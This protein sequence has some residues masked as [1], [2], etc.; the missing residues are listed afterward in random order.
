MKLFDENMMQ[1]VENPK[2]WKEVVHQAVQLLVENNKATWELEQKIYE[3]TE[4]FGAYYVLE[5]GIALVHGPAG[6]HC[7]QAATSTLILN[8]EIEFNN[9]ED[10]TARIIVT[11]S[12]PDAN[13]HLSLIQQFGHYF[14]ND[15]FKQKALKVKSLEEFLALIKNYEV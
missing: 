15:E 8:K 14:M 4:L 1:W 3:S 11:L 9:Q 10:K 6:D 12:A 13:T 5:K 2:D 7:K